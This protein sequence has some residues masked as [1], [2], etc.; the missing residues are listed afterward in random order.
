MV[1]P[2]AVGGDHQVGAKRDRSGFGHGPH[3]DH[4]SRLFQEPGDLGSHL[5]VEPGVPGGLSGEEIEEIPLGH[6]GNEPAPRGQVGEI[7]D[8]YGDV[9]DLR[10]QLPHFLMRQAEQAVQEPELVHDLERRGM[11]R[12]APE[13]A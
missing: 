3:T 1:C 9:A 13:V 5:H 8:L 10:R 12:V 2:P 11:D 4:A 6:H 7:G